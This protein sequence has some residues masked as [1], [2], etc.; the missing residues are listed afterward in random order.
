MSLDEAIKVGLLNAKVVRVLTGFTAQASGRTIYDVPATLAGIDIAQARFD[1][2]V[3]HNQ[4][5]N[6]TESPQAILDPF[7]PGN[8]LLTATQTTDYRSDAQ[9]AKTNILGGDWLLR[10]TEAPTRFKADTSIPSQGMSFSQNGIVQQT[11]PLNPQNRSAVEL[12]YTQPFLQG[13]GFAVN[14]APIVIARIDTERSFF[15]Y[16]DGVQE[17]VRGVAEAYWGFSQARTEQWARQI[18]TDVSREQFE[19]EL[20]RLKVGLASRGDE[21]QARLTYNQFRSQLVAA[22]AVVLAR[23]GALRNLLGLPPSDGKAIVPS[24]PP[25]SQ[26]FKKDWKKLLQVAEERRPDIIELKLVL[27]ADQQRLIQAENSALPRLDG[28]ALYRWNGLDGEAPNGQRVSSGPGQFTD[29]S[30]GVNFSVPLGLRE[31]RARVRQSSLVIARD[32]ANLEQGMHFA[33][34][35]LAVVVR[36]TDSAYQQYLALRETRKAASD[37][38]E[39]QIA[40]RRTGRAIY[41]DVLRALQ[42]WG[43]AVSAESAALLSYNTQL[44]NL[45]R[46]T[47]TI[48]ETHGL[49]FAEERFQAAGPLGRHFPRGYPGP[50]SVE[51][52]PRRYPP[53]EVRDNALGL[54]KPDLGAGAEELLPVPKKLPR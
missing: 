44:A 28:V 23:E 8:T 37:N 6:R 48:L 22:K 45:E 3:V 49:V 18:Q 31:G 25:A 32:R 46:Q 10:W 36:D 42:A 9:L 7:N 26:R 33:A 17:L 41:L 27:E 2:R 50:V 52:E 24:S 38:L 19:R 47:G 53:E 1:P 20:A 29:W 15:Q 39:V 12:S 40:A 14:L 30:V 35:T 11:F 54:K 43:D 51:G 34:H 5:V 21:A 16:K 4:S 13:G